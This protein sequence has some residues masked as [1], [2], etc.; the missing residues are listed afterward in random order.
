ME[1]AG[2]PGNGGQQ[3]CEHQEGSHSSHEPVVEVEPVWRKTNCQ[4]T[5]FVSKEL[6]ANNFCKQR[7]VNKQ[8]WQTKS[9]QQ[10]TF[11]KK[12]CQQTTFVNKKCL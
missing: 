12:N 8:L 1:I 11:A 10:A 6:S 7:I 3:R 9:C 5:N 4:Q 2:K